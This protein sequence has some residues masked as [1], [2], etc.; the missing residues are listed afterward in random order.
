VSSRGPQTFLLLFDDLS[1]GPGAGKNLQF[2]GERMLGQL[3]ASDVVGMATTSGLEPVIMPTR[4]RGVLGAAISRL[5]GRLVDTADP[6]FI[7][8]REVVE[9]ERPVQETLRDVVTRECGA[10]NLDGMCAVQIKTNARR[11]A[12]GSQRRLRDQLDAVRNAI[13]AMARVPAARVI[14]LLS[15]GISL[16]SSPRIQDDVE[17]LSDVAARSG[18]QLYALFDEPDGI[19]MKDRSP[20]RTKSR[21]DEGTFLLGGLQ[22]VASAAGGHAFKTIG[23]ADRFFARIVSETSAVYR[24]GL[25]LPV[26]TVDTTKLRTIVKVRRA[27]AHV[28]S[29]GR[30]FAGVTVAPLTRDDAITLKLEQGGNAPAVPL[31]VATR[32]RKDASGGMQVMVDA[33]ISG[34]AAAPI[35]AAFA[36]LDA[37][38]KVVLN[39][40]RDLPATTGAEH[41]ILFTMKADAGDYRLRFVAADGADR[42]GSAEVPVSARFTR[43]GPFGLSDVL[44]VF[45]DKSGAQSF[46]A[47]DDMPASAAQLSATLELYPDATTLPGATPL[48]RIVLAPTGSSL[49]SHEMTV[50]PVSASDRWTASA[51]VPLAGLAAGSYTLRMDVL[52]DGT[53]VGSASRVLHR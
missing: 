2:A 18:V 13:D 15:A 33:R 27:G 21:R 7:S 3:A 28:R 19:N 11:L 26:A 37:G 42:I 40:R 12:V 20:E 35:S 1:F 43:A 23:Q 47:S 38:G 48:V 30:A 36:L 41:Q 52:L 6:Y 17:Q 49:A 10:P 31:S 22:A 29:T 24:L 25:E 4:D 44:T 16:D 50:V 45:L 53:V 34:S 14:M 46:S 9:I 51:A 32:I 39:S 8:A 5:A